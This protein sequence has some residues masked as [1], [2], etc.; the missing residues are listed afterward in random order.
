MDDFRE[1]A[2]HFKKYFASIC[3]PKDDSS[4]LPDS[5]DLITPSSCFSTFTFAD[6][7]ILKIIRSLDI[8]KAHG[9]DEISVRL[10][11]ISD[12]A[13]IESLSLIY[14]N[15]YENGTFP[16]IWK[17]SNIIPFHKKGDKQISNN[18]RPVHCYPCSVKYLKEFYLTQYL[19]IFKKMISLVNISLGF[20]QMIHAYISY[21][22]LY[23]IFMLPLM[24]VHRSM[25]AAYI[26]T[27]LKN[28]TKFGMRGLFTRWNV[29]A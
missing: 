2:S 8:N 26:W 12:N 3:T 11:K 21:F 18:Y 27:C 29:L 17:K 9:H 28:L 10:I 7:E 15:S 19:S 25:L 4:C 23:I 24:S 20:N 1:K 5:V 6:D 16:A 14:R 13:I 22:Q